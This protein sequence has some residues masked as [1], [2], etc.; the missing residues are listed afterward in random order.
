MLMNRSLSFWTLL[1]GMLAAVGVAA[2]ERD[3]ANYEKILFPIYFWTPVPAAGGTSWLTELWIRNEGDTSVDAFPLSPD[4]LTSSGCFNTMRP[5]RA[6]APRYTLTDGGLSGGVRPGYLGVT[7]SPA[8]GAFL[9]VE[10]GTLAKLNVSLRLVETTTASA[11]LFTRLPVVEQSQFF[12]TSRS[13]MAVHAAPPSRM[14]LRVYDLESHAGAVVR[15]KISEQTGH[16]VSEPFCCRVVTDVYVEDDLQFDYL[17][18]DSCSFSLGCPEGARYKP[19][20]IQIL[21]LFDRYPTLRNKVPGQGFRIE[22][23]PITPGLRVWGFVSVTTSGGNGANH[24][25]IYTP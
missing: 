6:L 20:F 16:G 10:K 2:Q 24:V 12:E 5:F 18:P 25:E 17:A 7:E 15:I 21:N 1:F 23:V 3:L 13:I 19:G 9:W 14:A 11:A 22:I 8:P 4:C